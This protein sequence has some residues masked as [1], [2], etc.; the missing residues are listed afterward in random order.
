MKLFRKEKKPAGAYCCPICKRG[1]RHAG[2]SDAVIGPKP[3]GRKPSLYLVNGRHLFV[4]RG[5]ADVRRVMMGFGLSKP[6][7][8]GISPGEKFEDGRTAEDI[9]KTAVRVPALIGRMEDS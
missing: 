5:R 4:G 7:I 1:Y 9:I 6:R 2:M 8:Q 3:E